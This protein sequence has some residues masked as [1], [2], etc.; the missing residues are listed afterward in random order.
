[1][2]IDSEITPD[3]PTGAGTFMEAVK[4]T[5]KPRILPDDPFFEMNT[6]DPANDLYTDR[7]KKDI[8]DMSIIDYL[9]ANVD[10]HGAN[11]IYNYQKD[12]I[13]GKMRLDSLKGIDNDSAFAGRTFSPTLPTNRLAALTETVCISEEMAQKLSEMTPESMRR[14]MV[15]FGFSHEELACMDMRLRSMQEA[16]AAGKQFREAHLNTDDKW[17]SFL[18]GGLAFVTEKAGS[19]TRRKPCLITI[20]QDKIKQLRVD[21]FGNTEFRKMGF[22]SGIFN[23]VSTQHTHS[24]QNLDRVVA[25]DN[26][27]ARLSQIKSNTRLMEGVA[28]F[29]SIAVTA[30]KNANV[31]LTECANRTSRLRGTS[32]EFEKIVTTLKAI[33]QASEQMGQKGYRPSNNDT[34]YLSELH[35]RLQKNCIEYL[36]HKTTERRKGKDPSQYALNRIELVTKIQ[37][38]SA[39]A[40]KRVQMA[41]ND[42]LSRE[43]IKMARS[44]NAI[45]KLAQQMKPLTD[46][47]KAEKS[48]NQS[49]ADRETAQARLKEQLPDLCKKLK[50]FSDSAEKLPGVQQAVEMCAKSLNEGISNLGGDTACG[51]N[52]ETRSMLDSCGV[53]EPSEV[54]KEDPSTEIEI[55][56][57]PSVN[58][59]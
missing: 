32:P 27:K 56:T 55:D 33:A 29:Q 31:F 36:A 13:D 37:E 11:I 9:C 7:A 34:N 59:L 18:S 43:N 26:Q 58:Q 21:A 30:K 17:K 49:Q 24:K 20:P 5:D 51:I 41:W 8:M 28:G 19:P 42:E 48:Q 38:Y 47:L 2:T 50:E 16:L 3:N 15:Q 53:E 6:D 44:A 23:H 54:V 25:A 39:L 46:Y 14:E 12:P 57:A 4:G 10:R 45:N 1:M 22:D 40:G 52:E 35:Q